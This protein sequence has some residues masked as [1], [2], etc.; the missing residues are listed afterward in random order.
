MIRPLALLLTVALAGCQA[1]P[2]DTAGGVQ[3]PS[4]RGVSTRDVVQL[5]N[6]QR[7][8]LGALRSDARLSRAAKRHS[9]HMARQGR[10]GHRGPGGSTLMQRVKRAGYEPCLA[11]ENVAAGQQS[12]RDVVQ[13]WMTSPGHR[14]NIMIRQA[15]DVGI[16]VA[17]DASGRLYWT[18]VLARPCG[19]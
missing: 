2:P 16:G 17:S 12:A 3:T 19:A 8:S 15:E 6:S 1:P 11:A 14:R 18:M 4:T 9:E 13:A 10:I 5:T 7:R